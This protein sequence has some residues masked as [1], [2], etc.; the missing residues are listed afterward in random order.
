MQD[1]LSTFDLPDY[2]FAVELLT[3]ELNLTDDGA[4]RRALV[5]VER[6]NTPA[7]RA[8][9]NRALEREIRY[10]G[11]ADLAYLLRFVSGKEPG[12]P[13]REIVRDVA[14][15]LKVDV[16]PLGSDREMVEELV[17]NYATQQFAKFTPEEQQE[18]LVSLGVERD[19]A[20]AFVKKSAGVFA[21]PALIQAFDI[22]IVQG[23]VKNIIFG[24]IA[25]LIG[26]QLSARLFALLAGRFPWWV[27]WVGPAA[28]TVSIGWTVADL[29]GPAYRKTIPLVLYIGLCSLRERHEKRT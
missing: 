23:L 9:M 16:S 4:L 1:V 15:T 14:R 25:K 6:E 11:S 10:V 26:R 20:A 5:A 27:R 24:T 21:F 18:M 3:G 22:I 28:W 2:T 8:E 7:A 29:Q 13:F 17:Q 19:R 12:V